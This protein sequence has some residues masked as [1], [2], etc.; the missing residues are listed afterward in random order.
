MR[1]PTVH[2]ICPPGE[3][4]DITV[5]VVDAKLEGPFSINLDLPDRPF[6]SFSTLSSQLYGSKCFKIFNCRIKR[7]KWSSQSPRRLISPTRG[8]IKMSFKGTGKTCEHT[9]VSV[10]SHVHKRCRW[11]VVC[12][13]L[14]VSKLQI[15][16]SQPADKGWRWRSFIL[17]WVSIWTRVSGQMMSWAVHLLHSLDVM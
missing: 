4:N 15:K 14:L 17:V 5:E 8:A 10:Y 16:K 7:A 9:A 12:Y 1:A 6:T 3:K 2:N 11:T 13:I